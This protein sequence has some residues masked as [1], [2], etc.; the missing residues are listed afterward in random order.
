[1]Q[2]VARDGKAST[3]YLQRK[4]SIGY[5]SAAKLIERM[6]AEGL[7]S[8][9][10]H[11]GR[12][13]VLMGRGGIDGDRAHRRGPT[14][15]PSCLC[16]GCGAACLRHSW[17]CW[18]G[19]HRPRT[20]LIFRAASGRRRSIASRP[21]SNGLTTL[22]S[23]F[24]QIAPN[25]SISARGKLLLSRPGRMLLDYDPPSRIRLVAPGDWRLIFYDGSIQQV[26]V[27]PIGQT[28]LGV[29]LEEH[30]S[31]A[32]GIRVTEVARSGDEI[33]ISLRREEALDQGEVTLVFDET[34][35]ALRR[36]VV[37]DAQGLSTTI[38]L[39]ASERDVLLGQST[40]STGA[41][42]AFSD[43]PRTE[44]RQ[45]GFSFTRLLTNATY[46]GRVGTCLPDDR[47]A[48]LGQRSIPSDTISALGACLPFAAGWL[49]ASFR[50]S[51]GRR[52]R[53]RQRRHAGR[54]ADHH[55]QQSG[56]HQRAGRRRPDGRRHRLRHQSQPAP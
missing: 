27:I 33:A 7:I 12:R 1:M 8:T 2:I 5:N 45:E 39:E 3:S 26:N 44:N 56:R 43:F 6:E 28:P 34:P 9:A 11:V 19:R 17:S 30:I 32:G 50:R 20:S 25:G 55:R 18:P 22:R 13:Q 48:L 15:E 47:C 14:I 46:D 40:C 35:L 4:L 49:V 31:L 24:V 42:R 54:P 37:V 23:G 10:D 53:R 51:A 52:R 21:I 41:I 16:E 36:W 38:V 29:L